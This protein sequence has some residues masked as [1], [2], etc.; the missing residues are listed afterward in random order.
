MSKRGDTSGR[1]ELRKVKILDM[2][3]LMNEPGLT[4]DERKLVKNKI[5]KLKAGGNPLSA[6]FDFFNKGGYVKNKKER[7]LEM[8]SKEEKM[9][10]LK[11]LAKGLG[12]P[13]VKEVLGIKPG[14]VQKKARGGVAKK[15]MGGLA[16]KKLSYGGKKAK[17]YRGVVKKK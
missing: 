16:N 6:E 9:L 14:P 7:N 12:M 3:K 17:D 15:N 1:E 10:A 13:T 4:S 8:A 2:Q 5:K 11:K